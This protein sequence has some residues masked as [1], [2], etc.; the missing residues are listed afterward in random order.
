M[1]ET[2]AFVLGGLAL[3]VATRRL[4][5]I[6]GLPVAILL[7]VAGGAYSLL[8]GPHAGLDPEI[9]LVLV[10]PPLLYAAGLNPDPPMRPSAGA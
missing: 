5:G 7:V 8:P 4:A 6:S 3:L 10:I 9:V 2:L 1:L